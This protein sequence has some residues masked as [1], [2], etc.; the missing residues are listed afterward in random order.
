MEY[1]RNIAPSEVFDHS[2][3]G[4]QALDFSLQI[5]AGLL[6]FSAAHP[7]AAMKD[8]PRMDPTAIIQALEILRR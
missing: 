5:Q 3:P 8:F 4:A 6:D 1:F 7:A 2:V